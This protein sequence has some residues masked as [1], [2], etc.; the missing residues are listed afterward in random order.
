MTKF[1]YGCCGLGAGGEPFPWV[2]T[3]PCS[4]AHKLSPIDYEH[5]RNNIF[6]CPN[7]STEIERIDAPCPYCQAPLKGVYDPVTVAPERILCP[8]TARDPKS[9]QNFRWH[10]PSMAVKNEHIFRSIDWNGP[11]TD[12]LVEWPVNPKDQS[13]GEPSL[14]FAAS[15]PKG[16]SKESVVSYT[17]QVPKL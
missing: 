14:D 1:V 9:L 5:W 10:I 15:G 6:V 7:R 2:Y 12:E 8:L 13:F 17:S 16:T 11:R 4:L 3:E